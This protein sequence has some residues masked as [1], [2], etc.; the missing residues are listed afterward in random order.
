MAATMTSLDE[1]ILT[2]SVKGLG[3]SKITRHGSTREGFV[4]HVIVNDK[5]LVFAVGNSWNS[6]LT[7]LKKACER[8]HSSHDNANGNK[9][10]VRELQCILEST[11]VH[12]ASWV[13][14]YDFE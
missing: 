7:N 8:F 10:D 11:L 4:I 14:G 3:I 9:I 13:M 6:A 5:P 12:N 1:L 2:D